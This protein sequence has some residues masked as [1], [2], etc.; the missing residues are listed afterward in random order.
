MVMQTV[1]PKKDSR[2]EGQGQRVRDQHKEGSP[3]AAGKGWE[4]SFGCTVGTVRGPGWGRCTEV[5]RLVCVP[6]NV[7]GCRRHE[8]AGSKLIRMLDR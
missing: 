3:E 4:H 7:V 2:Q 1:R 8:G 5:G 6:M